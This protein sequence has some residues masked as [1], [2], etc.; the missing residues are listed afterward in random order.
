MG[1]L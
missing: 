1:W